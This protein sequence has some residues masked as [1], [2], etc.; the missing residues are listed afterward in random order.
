MMASTSEALVSSTSH[1]PGTTMPLPRPN[2][3]NIR[4]VSVADEEDEDE[5]EDDDEDDDEEG[6]EEAVRST[7]IMLSEELVSIL[8]HEKVTTSPP[9]RIS[10]ISSAACTSRPRSVGDER[11][12]VDMSSEPGPP[13]IADTDSP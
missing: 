10:N 4:D 3:R 12:Y 2:S 6:A 8:N 1:K 5:D 7:S 13:K 9:L 11:R